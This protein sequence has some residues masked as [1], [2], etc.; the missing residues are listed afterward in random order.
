MRN[1]GFEVGVSYES[2]HI[3]WCFFLFCLFL[4]LW[5]VVVQVMHGRWLFHMQA[6][7]LLPPHHRSL[8]CERASPGALSG[9]AQN[10]T[11]SWWLC[12]CHTS[13]KPSCF[14]LLIGPKL[15]GP[16]GSAAPVANLP[17]ELEL[18]T[19][20]TDPGT[21]TTVEW[22][23]PQQIK[24]KQIITRIA[25]G[26]SVNHDL[27]LWDPFLCL[28]SHFAVFYSSVPLFL[29]LS[30]CL[31][32]PLL[33]QYSVQSQRCFHDTLQQSNPPWSSNPNQEP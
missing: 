28:F 24:S 33:F 13:P 2:A 17:L 16:R 8:T 11:G 29:P 23:V 1:I 14:I 7:Q 32:V 27:S 30:L 18:S 5:S 19:L 22:L 6:I 3:L 4:N 20:T 15:P 12:Y 31:S 26:C 9:S 10:L 21:M 25:A